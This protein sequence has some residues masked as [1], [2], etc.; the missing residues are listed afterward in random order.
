MSNVAINR[1]TGEILVVN[2]DG[3]WE[4]AR[5]ARNPQSGQEIF[6]NGRD[7]A[8]VP[9]APRQPAD[10]LER[11]IGISGPEAGRRLAMG[12]RDVAEGVAGI[13]NMLLD[14]PASIRNAGLN[15][16]GMPSEP[17]YS[18]RTSAALS[19]L[20]LPEPATPG[21]RMTS[22]VSRNV[23]A[24]APMFAAGAALQ[25]AR[26]A[27]RLAEMLVGNLPSQIAGAGAA[28]AAGQAAAESGAGATGQLAAALLG[29]TAGSL[30]VN[31]LQAGGRSGAAIVQPFTDAGR[32][33]IAA[34][35][36]LRASGDPEGLPAR[37]A[38]GLNDPTRRLPS[39]P[40][41]TG[42]ASRDPGVMLLESGMRSQAGQ[43]LPLGQ[44]PAVAIRDVEARRNAN[45]LMALLTGQ[46]GSTAETRGASLR[47]GLNAADNAM[48]ERV[49]MAFQIA[50]GNNSN[51]YS[52]NPVMDEAGRV[53]RMFD[54]T[55]GGGGVPVELRGVLDDIESLG[56]VSLDQAQNLRARLMEVAGKASAA[57]DNRLASAAGSIA[58]RLENTIDDPRWMQAVALRREQG[59]AMGRTEGGD[60]PRAAVARRRAP[61]DGS[62]LQ[63]AGRCAPSPSPD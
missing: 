17:T 27:P 36:L 51:R 53:T 32:Q 57:G 14:L 15:A 5:R 18:Q 6:F 33:Q 21:E 8:P 56:A 29:G 50:R 34:D 42:M 23:A 44:S 35:V 19:A 9:A 45:R 59:Q 41:T 38:Q 46:D 52:L 63:G 54:P 39:S 24:Q 62:L 61:D 28:G 48:G 25:G 31:A 20:G 22:A 10:A 1:E 47:T 12:V 40:V 13:P 55:Q 7:W 49:D 16:L 43:N 3:A 11:T 2:Q 4:P 58:T 60:R 26:Q 37:I 30:G